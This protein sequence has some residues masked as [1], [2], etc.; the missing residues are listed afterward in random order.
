MSNI[1]IAGI[2][3]GKNTGIAIINF[4]KEI[5]TLK[6]LKSPNL[7]RIIKILEKGKVLIIATDVSRCPNLIKRI[8][9]QTGAKIFTPKKSLTRREKE[10]L[11]KNFFKL[12]KNKHERDALAASFKALKKYEKVRRR[13]ERK[14][15]E[16]NLEKFT[17]RIFERIIRGEIEN[18]KEGIKKMVL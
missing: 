11:T 14:L 15:K 3:T 10:K 1:L 7:G 2:D 18:I 16:K 17:G 8:A 6:T 4:D 12:I 5:L 9:S 13:I